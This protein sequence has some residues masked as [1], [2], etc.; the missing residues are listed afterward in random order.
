[1]PRHQQKTQS[2]TVK[3]NVTTRVQQ[4]YHSRP[5][6]H[7]IAEAEDKDSNLAFMNMLQVLKEEINK[8]IEEI[9]KNT[10]KQWKKTKNKTRKWKQSQ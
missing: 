9:Y 4:L 2:I 7:T 10:N 8:S 5:W 1:M 3:T 6:K